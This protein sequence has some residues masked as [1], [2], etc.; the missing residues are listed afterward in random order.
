MALVFPGPK[1]ADDEW[2]EE[3]LGHHASIRDDRFGDRRRSVATSDNKT[4]EKFARPIDVDVHVA[5]A[6]IE[7]RH[8]TIRTRAQRRT[9]T[10]QRT[11]LDRTATFSEYGGET[12]STVSIVDFTRYFRCHGV[13]I[14]EQ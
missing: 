13:K 1:F 3:H 12:F 11:D 7:K 4:F 9:T 10:R 8:V 2:T 5:S 6:R 14:V